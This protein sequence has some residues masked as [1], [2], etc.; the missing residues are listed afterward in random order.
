MPATDTPTR[1]GLYGGTFDPIHLGHLI[2]A[3]DALQQAHLDRLFFL[4]AYSAPLR[5]NDAETPPGDRLAMVRLAVQNFPRF[6]V[7]DFD[8]RQGRRV[9]SIETVRHY[10]AQFPKAE[11]FFL[12]GRDQYDQLA[13][14]QSIDELRREV[15]FLC[16]AREGGEDRDS[17]PQANKSNLSVK[18]LPTRRIDISATEIRTRI[19]AGQSVR[20]LLP[21]AVADYLEGNS[22]YSRG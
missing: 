6:S 13:S 17:E 3:E 22:L 9:Y 14:W 19:L 12:I 7:D 5:P 10:R 4:P 11:L 20:S 8:I 21:A 2:I 15:T 18:F 16:A 1:I